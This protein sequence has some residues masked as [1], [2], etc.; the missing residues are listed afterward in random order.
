L[1][2]EFAIEAQREYNISVEEE[3]EEIEFPRSGEKL[4]CVQRY[5]ARSRITKKH[6]LFAKITNQKRRCLILR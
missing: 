1:L 3:R 5:K 6:F 2:I 4:G